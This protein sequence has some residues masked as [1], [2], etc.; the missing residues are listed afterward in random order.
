MMKYNMLLKMLF[1]VNNILRLIKNG[2]SKMVDDFLL[3]FRNW[4][5]GN[6]TEEAGLDEFERIESKHTRIRHDEDMR[7]IIRV[8]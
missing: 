3:E 1:L 5:K 7:E 6:S 2:G 4:W 8:H